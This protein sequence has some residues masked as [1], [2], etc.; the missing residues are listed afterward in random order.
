[1]E[2]TDSS[3]RRVIPF[4]DKVAPQLGLE[5]NLVP[6]LEIRDVNGSVRGMDSHVQQHCPHTRVRM[7]QLRRTDSGIDFKDVQIRQPETCSRSPVPIRLVPP[8][9]AVPSQDQSCKRCF[10]ALLRLVRRGQTG[11]DKPVIDQQVGKSPRIQ[12]S[13][14][15][16]PPLRSRPSSDCR[17]ETR[18]PRLV[19][20]P[21]IPPE[22]GSYLRKRSE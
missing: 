21:L 4:S 9:S 11:R 15:G 18:Q 14:G 12:D 16:S 8:G 2:V 5:A 7:H 3:L 10:F 1:M 20:R 17:I 19:F 6:G 13:P 22:P